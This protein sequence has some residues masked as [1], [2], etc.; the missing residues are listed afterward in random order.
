MSYGIKITNPTGGLVIDSQFEN[1]ALKNETPSTA[2]AGSTFPPTGATYGDLIA[3]KP[4]NANV[5]TYV[6]KEGD[7][8]FGDYSLYWNS[9][10]GSY[11]YYV[12]EKFSSNTAATSG[13]GMQVYGPSNELFFD[14]E[15]LETQGFTVITTGLL[16]NTTPIYYPSSTGSVDD[17]HKYY[18]VINSTT[19]FASQFFGGVSYYEYI[20]TAT[21]E[22]R[23]KIAKTT[24]T[25]NLN[26]MI[27]KEKI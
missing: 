26:Y 16:D 25:G 5:D 24:Y 3:V 8:T 19:Y 9:A 18:C 13:Y 17:L 23:I 21:G 7:D 1:L 2:A 4:T 27:I 6:F 10:A 14:S 15:Q 11:S 22:G 20:W 12:L